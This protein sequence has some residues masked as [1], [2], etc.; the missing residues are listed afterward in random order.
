MKCYRGYDI[1]YD[2][3]YVV[4][5]EMFDWCT[6][7]FGSNNFQLLYRTLYFHINN[8]YDFTTEYVNIENWLLS[9]GATMI[10]GFVWGTKWIVTDDVI[11][12][13]SVRWS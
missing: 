6:E 12:L 11:L 3:E 4:A 7:K 8:M 1:P 9:Q 2:V 10:P 5:I 13:F